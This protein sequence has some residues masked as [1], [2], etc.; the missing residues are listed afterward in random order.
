MHNHNCFL[1]YAGAKV[2]LFLL[3][4]NFKGKK[5]DIFFILSI[6]YCFTDMNYIAFVK[7]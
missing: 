5:L 4:A 3:S 6:I 1:N 2:Q 7:N